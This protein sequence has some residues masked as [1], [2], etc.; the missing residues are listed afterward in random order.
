LPGVQTVVVIIKF[1]SE[2]DVSA[3]RRPAPPG[4]FGKRRRSMGANVT[5]TQTILL[6]GPV[7]IIPDGKADSVEIIPITDQTLIHGKNIKRLLR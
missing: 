4:M 3:F 1:K 2:V 6:D 5:E 7:L